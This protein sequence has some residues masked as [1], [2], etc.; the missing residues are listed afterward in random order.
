[1]T[2]LSLNLNSD[3]RTMSA[4]CAVI[5]PHKPF[6]LITSEFFDF[7]GRVIQHPLNS[8]QYRF[9]VKIM[10]KDELLFAGIENAINK[11]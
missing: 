7:S 8:F 11:N 4:V 5:V 3:A 9:G 6:P 10:P 1:M 2:Q